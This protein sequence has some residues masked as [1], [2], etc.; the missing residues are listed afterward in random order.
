[1]KI[2]RRQL[3]RIIGE[4]LST[5]LSEQIPVLSSDD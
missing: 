4:E 2:T 5:I 1:M 3:K